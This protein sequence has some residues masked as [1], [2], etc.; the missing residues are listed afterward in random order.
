[1]DRNQKKTPPESNSRTS[2]KRIQ[3]VQRAL[4]ILNC[5]SATNTALTLSQIAASLDLN[6]GT[7]HGILNTLYSNG[8]VSQNGAG[9]YML[10]AEI[11]NKALLAPDTRRRLCID[12]AHDMMQKLS[13]RFQAN[14][15]L[16]AVEDGWLQ[17]LDSTEPTNCVFVVR[18]AV[19]RISLHGSA[20]GKVLLTYLPEKEQTDYL[21]KAPFTAFT[22]STKNTRQKLLAEFAFIREKGYSYE[23]SEL[24]MGVSAIAVPI[25]SNYGSTLFG[26]ISLTGTGA[27]ISKNQQEIIRALVDASQ[28]LQSR[29]QF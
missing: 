16:F 1:M 29:L 18:R 2:G 25:F 24:F 4:S 10:G 17:M 3:S 5:F 20:S 26:T 21:A 14:S 23:E 15:S 11:F 13:N 7:V 22:D 28:N 8:Y 9:Q 12:Y 6:K 27:V 19:S